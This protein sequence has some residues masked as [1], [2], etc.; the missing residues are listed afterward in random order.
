M[1][2]DD[3]TQLKS[4]GYFRGR[5]NNHLPAAQL[6]DGFAGIGQARGDLM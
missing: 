1:Q 3:L 2:T 6:S 5:H 4:I